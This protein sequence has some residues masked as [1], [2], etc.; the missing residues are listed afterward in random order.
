MNHARKIASVALVSLVALQ[1]ASPAVAQAQAEDEGVPL[2]MMRTESTAAFGSKRLR[3]LVAALK[4]RAGKSSRKVLPLTKTEVWTVPK[5]KVAAVQNEASQTWSGHE[6][7]CS[8]PGTSF[9]GDSPRAQDEYEA[10]GDGGGA[11]ASAAT[12]GVGLMARRRRRWWSM[13]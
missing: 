1:A 7:T 8:G 10:A 9:C 12:L 11:K 6:P 3:K 5:D 4:K 2:I 13:R